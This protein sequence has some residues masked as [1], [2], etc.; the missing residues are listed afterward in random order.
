[1]NLFDP[2][3]PVAIAAKKILSEQFGQI[4]GVDSGA[5]SSKAAKVQKADSKSSDPDDESLKDREK[6]KAPSVGSDKG[7]N[8]ISGDKS[9]VVVNPTL[10]VS[11]GTDDENSNQFKAL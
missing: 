4:S 10:D 7:K 8:E 1:M 2:E 9:K 5:K 6:G 3:N 11:T